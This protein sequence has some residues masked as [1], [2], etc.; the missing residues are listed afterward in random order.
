MP[1]IHEKSVGIAGIFNWKLQFTGNEST[2]IRHQNQKLM[3]A[4]L[5]NDKFASLDPIGTTP[6]GTI[7]NVTDKEFALLDKVIQLLQYLFILTVSKLRRKT[8]NYKNNVKYF[9]ILIIN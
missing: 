8:F 6:K 1:K 5:Y 3:I 7:P 4:K 2:T 9:K